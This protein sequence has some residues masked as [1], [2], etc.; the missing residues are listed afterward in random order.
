MITKEIFNNCLSNFVHFF[1]LIKHFHTFN[2]PINK[3]AQKY[4]TNNVSNLLHIKLI[5]YF[6]I[7]VQ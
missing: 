6:N 7:F 3:F 4:E 1:K 5:K 2:I